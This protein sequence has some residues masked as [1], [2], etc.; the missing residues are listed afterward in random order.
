MQQLLGPNTLIYLESELLLVPVV[1]QALRV[2]QALIELGEE[3]QLLLILKKQ[4]AALWLLEKPG[5]HCLL[6]LTK[7]G[8][9]P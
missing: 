5:G 4:E 2:P 6:S 3:F 1:P 8:S 9:S 7:A